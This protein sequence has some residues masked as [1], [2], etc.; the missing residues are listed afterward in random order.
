MSDVTENIRKPTHWCML[1]RGGTTIASELAG[2]LA[3]PGALYLAEGLAP[4][5][6][7][8]IKHWTAQHIVAPYFDT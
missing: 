8:G 7:H 6:M 2:G 5:A 4:D 3:G 1:K